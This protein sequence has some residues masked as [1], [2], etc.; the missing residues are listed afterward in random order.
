MKQSSCF[1]HAVAAMVVICNAAGV[2]TAQPPSIN[3]PPQTPATVQLKGRAQIVFG[4]ARDHC[5]SGYTMDTPARAFRDAKGD[6]VLI[7]G[8]PTNFRLVGRSLNAISPASRDCRPIFT[9]AN[10]R[11]YEHGRYHE[12]IS[13][14]YTT[15][16]K[17]VYGLVHNEWYANLVGSPCEDAKAWLNFITLVESNDGG[18]RFS[19]P[20]NYIVLKP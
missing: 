12:W 1:L 19:H 6:V 14:T 17:K 4:S 3:N 7:A 11:T 15:D 16:G 2:S 5:G 9:S 20:K 13:S 8:D 10:D 18:A